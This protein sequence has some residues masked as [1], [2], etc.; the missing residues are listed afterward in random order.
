MK[1]IA[2]VFAALLMSGVFL[3]GC[4][5]DQLLESYD[6]ILQFAGNFGLTDPLALKGTRHFGQ[7]RYTGTYTADYEGFTGKEFVFGGT[8]LERKAGADIVV[9]CSMDT[10]DGT[11]RIFWEPGAQEQVVLLQTDGT[12]AATISLPAGGNYLGVECDNFTGS[13]SITVE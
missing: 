9:M 4:S 2:I 8:A 7:D 13:V 1:L 3:P 5:K 6:Q 10:D 11:A 12:Y